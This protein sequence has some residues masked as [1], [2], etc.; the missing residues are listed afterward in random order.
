M[1]PWSY[2]RTWSKSGGVKA[3]VTPP[4]SVHSPT[5]TF[6]VLSDLALSDLAAGLLLRVVAIKL[7]LGSLPPLA[8]ASASCRWT[9]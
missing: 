2:S 4:M 7:V 3:P 1:P 8:R 6:P 5:P 9:G